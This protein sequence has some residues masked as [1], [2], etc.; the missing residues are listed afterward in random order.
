MPVLPVPLPIAVKAPRNVA[1]TAAI[2]ATSDRSTIAPG[3]LLQKLDDFRAHLNRRDR[4]RLDQALSRAKDG[5]IAACAGNV[6]RSEASCEDWAYVR[7]V[8][9]TGMMP[10]FK[11]SLCP[12]PSNG[13]PLEDRSAPPPD[14][15]RPLPPLRT[16]Y[17][18]RPARLAQSGMVAFRKAGIGP[19]QPTSGPSSRSRA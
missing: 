2:R 4:A 10:R 12:K 16:T 1:N 7:A 3:D 11:A 13:P 18:Q 5:G 17:G 9:R 14:R 6:D 15:P 19:F 8:H